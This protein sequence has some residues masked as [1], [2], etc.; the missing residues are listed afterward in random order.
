MQ[1][2]H[3]RTETRLEYGQ[4][5]RGEREREIAQEPRRVGVIKASDLGIR[6]KSE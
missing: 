6:A 3:L 2:L 5:S 4:N 1:S